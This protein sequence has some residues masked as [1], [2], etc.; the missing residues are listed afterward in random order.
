M[1]FVVSEKRREVWNKELEILDE[2]KR[3]CHKHHLPYY[4]I[5]GTLLGAKRH[6][7][8]IPWDDDI[9]IVMFREHSCNP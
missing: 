1:D 9:D 7:G 2:I 8:F 5:G 3:L 6:G 4:A